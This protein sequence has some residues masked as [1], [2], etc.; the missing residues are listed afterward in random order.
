MSHSIYSPLDVD[1]DEIRLL[2]IL[3]QDPNEPDVLSCSMYKISL[4]SD[5][6]LG[7]LSYVWGDVSLSS[8]GLWGR[9]LIPTPSQIGRPSRGGL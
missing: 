4:N 2:D 6:E 8:K 1:N 3:P 9:R 5:P 7:A